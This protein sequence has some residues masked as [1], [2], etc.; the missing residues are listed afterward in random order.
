MKKRVVIRAPLLSY[1]GYGTHSRQIFR[2]LLSRDDVEINTQIVPWGITSWMINPDFEDGM[3]QEIMTRSIPPNADAKADITLQLQ[4]PNEWDPNLGKTNVGISACVET[5]VC[6]P[7]W[8]ECCNKMNRV[9]V[10]SEHTKGVLENSGN[11]NVPIAVIPESYYDIIAN[12]D[13]PTLDFDFSTD[14][15]FL[16]LGQFTGNNP[17]N[18]RKNIFYTVKWLCEAFVGD[19]DVGIVLKTNSGRNTTIDRVVTQQTLQQLLHEVR[20]GPYPRFHFLH[21]AMTP[22]EIASL[23]RHPTIK[24]LVALTRGEGFG[25]PILEAA[26]SGL[27]VIATNWSAHTEFLGKGRFI[28]VDYKLEKIHASRVDNSIFMEGA[29]WAQPKEDDAKQR[30]IK[31]RKSPSI[32]MEWAAELKE[33]LLV[34]YSQ[35]AIEK[36]YNDNLGYLFD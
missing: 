21:G 9:V 6:N 31:F 28:G 11:V 18:D 24:A 23:Y 35:S 36:T 30:L 17:E 26:A 29:K 32:P 16:L 22:F 14:F 8:V 10:P 2:W 20:R 7:Q 33:K 19:P 5:D 12:D 1:S 4:L 3:V 15:N 27:P 13:L 25:L 34:E